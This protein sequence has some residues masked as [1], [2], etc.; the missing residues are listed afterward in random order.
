MF[1]AEAFVAGTLLPRGQFRGIHFEVVARG[2][3]DRQAVSAAA[4]YL[5]ASKLARRDHVSERHVAAEKAALEC[6]T[7]VAEACGSRNHRETSNRPCLGGVAAHT[8]LSIGTEAVR[9]AL[10]G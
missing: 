10:V 5:P 1:Q 3:A 9:L 6:K 7:I 8:L 4:M 2:L